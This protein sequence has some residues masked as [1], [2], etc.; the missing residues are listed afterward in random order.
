MSSQKKAIQALQRAAAKFPNLRI[1]QL[2]DNARFHADGAGA[3]DLFYLS[4]EHL[5][6]A[7]DRYRLS[8]K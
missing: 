7:L 4:D 5:A 8:A 3:G 1:G 6:E 2:L